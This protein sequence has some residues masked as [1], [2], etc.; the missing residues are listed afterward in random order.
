M[1]PYIYIIHYYNFLNNIRNRITLSQISNYLVITY[2][3]ISSSI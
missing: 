1:P 2:E 3:K